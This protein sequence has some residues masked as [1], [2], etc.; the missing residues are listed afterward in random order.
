MP[1]YMLHISLV[2]TI[3][4]KNCITITPTIYRTPQ[5][6]DML[7]KMVGNHGDKDTVGIDAVMVGLGQEAN[8]GTA[9]AHSEHDDISRQSH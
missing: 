5:H 7:W 3:Q 1:P 2:H 9:R 6:K 4:R 8:T